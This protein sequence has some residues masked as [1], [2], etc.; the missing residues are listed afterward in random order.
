V[1]RIRYFVRLLAVAGGFWL[2]AAAPGFAQQL[3]EVCF[4]SGV[5][6]RAIRVELREGKV[7]LYP[8]VGGSPIEVA[9]DQVNRIGGPCGIAPPA[10]ATQKFGIHG[11]NTIGERLMPLLIDAFAK[12]Q[13]GTRSIQRPRAPEELDIEIRP[14]GATQPLAIIDFQ[15]KGSG[16]SANALDDKKA[17]IGMSSRPAN[18]DEIEKI[19]RKYSINL[20]APGNEHVVAL[21]GLAVIVN[22]DNPVKMLTLDQ[23]ARIFAG[24]I[25]NWKDVT[26][27][28]ANGQ[29]IPG[30][31]RQIRVHARD[32]KSGTYDTFVTLV[33]A[34]PDLP[35][36]QLSPQAVRYESSENLSDAVAKDFGAIGFIGLPYINKNHPLSIAS[37]CGLLNSPSKFTIKTEEYPLA[38][39]LFLYSLGTPSES[40]ANEILQFALSDDAQPTVVEAEFIDQSIEFQDRQ[41]Q[42]RWREALVSNPSTGLGLDKEI[43]AKMV[44]SFNVMMQNVRRSALVFRFEYGKSDLDV[45]ALQDVARLTR[46]LRSPAVAG[47]KFF[48]AGFADSVGGWASN[49]RLSSERAM[50]VVAELQKLGVATPKENV[51]ALSYMA[52]V[53]CNDTAAGQAKNRRVEVWIAQ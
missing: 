39:R 12:K 5:V 27:R 31:D 22:R 2:T 29:D 3:T 44:S 41:E 46:Y 9:Q 7:F 16:T 13:Y 48:I 28:D 47:K 18:K 17:V 49:A 15:A 32:N 14:P 10:A 1:L 30:P 43:P 21:D 25:S 23:I 34:P 4:K 45:R 50:R 8:E 26:Y 6:V 19:G 11:S 24:E 36:R 40:V 53:A 51:F 42:S 38:R 20:R 52:P 35:K 37:T 33:L